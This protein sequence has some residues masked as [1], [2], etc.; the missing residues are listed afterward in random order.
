MNDDPLLGALLSMARVVLE[1]RSQSL[2]D[3]SRALQVHPGRALFYESLASD[4]LAS[5]FPAGDSGYLFS[6][7]GTGTLLHRESLAAVLL[8]SPLIHAEASAASL[9]VDDYPAAVQAGVVLL[10]KL[11]SGQ[12]ASLPVIVQFSGVEVAPGVSIRLP[13]GVVRRAAGM[14]YGGG[15][16]LLLVSNADVRCAVVEPGADP[17]APQG[18]FDHS[19]EATAE[20]HERMTMLALLLGLEEGKPAALPVHRRILTPWDAQGY[21]AHGIEQPSLF[22][23][24]AYVD[25]SSVARLERW[26][27][28]VHRHYTPRL[29]LA[30][31]RLAI[32]VTHRLDPADGLVDAMIAL[33]SMFAGGS[34]AE[35]TFRIS[36][37]TAWLLEPADIS[38]RRLLHKELVGLYGVRSGIV[39]GSPVR[40]SDELSSLRDR[41][42]ALGRRAL[43]RLYEHHP[44]LLANDNRSLEIILGK[45]SRG[46]DYRGASTESL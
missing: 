14:S 28:I 22:G 11:A 21:G 44:D 26:G 8:V 35:L 6:S 10:R 40:H 36:A 46:H 33:E 37:A 24:Q 9:S 13:W 16:G 29:E 32:S 23:T 34:K 3:V 5:L 7:H 20:R 15:Q 45:A 4:P 18:F 27:R 19:L 2:T 38:A 41:A 30:V 1:E 39:H 17:Q 31:R 25:S 12:A 42:F 43:R